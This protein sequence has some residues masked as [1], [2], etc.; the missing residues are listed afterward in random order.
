MKHK[1][2]NRRPSLWIKKDSINF[3][4]PRSK[5]KHPTAPNNRNLSK[6]LRDAVPP[7]D[8]DGAAIVLPFGQHEVQNHQQVELRLRG[9]SIQPLHSP[10]QLRA[11]LWPRRQG[12]VHYPHRP[13]GGGGVVLGQRWDD[14]NTGSVVRGEGLV[15]VESEMTNLVFFL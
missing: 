5:S 15:E 3:S 13:E 6:I 10:H 4:I 14:G 2:C 7:Q 11:T 12:V 9:G 8:R 1:Y